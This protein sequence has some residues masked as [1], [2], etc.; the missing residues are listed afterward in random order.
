MTAL[1]QFYGADQ[2][3]VS[4]YKWFNLASMQ[5]DEMAMSERDYVA[6]LMSSAEIARAQ[7]LASQWWESRR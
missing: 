3:Y 4:A 1:G 7:R 2:D 5:G 6:G